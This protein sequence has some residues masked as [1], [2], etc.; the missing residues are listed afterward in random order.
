MQTFFLL[1]M[2][3]YM[4]NHIEWIDLGN[5]PHNIIIGFI[6]SMIEP[7]TYHK[8]L[9]V[10]SENI[11]EAAAGTRGKVWPGNCRGIYIL[12]PGCCP[13]T[14]PGTPVT[15]VVGAAASPTIPVPVSARV[16]ARLQARQLDLSICQGSSRGK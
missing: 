7:I 4:D 3:I 5:S 6:L 10:S 1:W 13:T 16:L 14:T 12:R 2:W 15:A 11:G 8:S 9:P